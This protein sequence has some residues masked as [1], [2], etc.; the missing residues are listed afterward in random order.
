MRLCV[1]WP[2]YEVGRGAREVLWRILFFKFLIFIFSVCY[3]FDVLLASE[4]MFKS[5]LKAANLALFR[6]NDSSLSRPAGQ[7]PELGPEFSLAKKHSVTIQ[8]TS[9]TLTTTEY[10]QLQKWL[11][12]SICKSICLEKTTSAF[13]FCCSLRPAAA[14]ADR[15]SR[16][17]SPTFFS[18]FCSH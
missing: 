13:V 14:S 10:S 16:R 17:I 6:N 3:V 4:S 5:P 7:S 9:V 11:R 1:S 18:Q 15:P 8:Q 2:N 12:K